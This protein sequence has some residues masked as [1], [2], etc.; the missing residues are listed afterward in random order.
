MYANVYTATLRQRITG[1]LVGVAAIISTVV[2]AVAVYA[3]IEDSLVGFIRDLPE[4]YLSII[5]ISA[6]GGFSSIVLGEM[7][8]LVAPLV[9]AGLAISIGTGAIAGEEQAGTI[10]L[11]LTN[12]I[13]RSEV[14]ISKLGAMITLAVLGGLLTWGGTELTLIAFDAS[15]AEVFVGAASTHLIAIT[16]FFGALAALVGSWTGDVTKSTAVSVTVLIGSFFAAGLLPLVEG[17]ADFARVFPWYYLNGSEPLLNGIDWSHIGVLA[18]A[19][20]VM[21]GG[22]LYGFERRDL[23]V[24][25]RSASVLDRLREHRLVGSVTSRVS[26]TADVKSIW[27]KSFSEHRGVVTLGA[28]AVASTSLVI[29]PLFAELGD[30][31]TQLGEAMPEA[32]LAAVGFA[33]FSTPEGWYWVEVFSIVVPAA[34]ITV[35][36][37]A[38]ARALAGEEQAQTMDLLLANPVKRSRVVVEKAVAMTLLSAVL[39]AAAFAGTL[40]GSVIA[41]LG[42]APSGI[43]AASLQAA[44]LGFS[45]GGMALAVGAATGSAKSAG[46]TGAGVA[47]AAYVAN[48]FFPISERLSGWAELSPFYYYGENEPLVNGVSL[49]NLAVLVALGVSLIGLAILA[50]E[51]RDLR[52]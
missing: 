23:Q 29:G 11:L 50:F 12:P 33:D 13:G 5:G 22:A 46:Y 24:G 28:T 27:V 20:L 49:T 37:M 17:A 30:T 41:G 34:V 40:G 16:V 48:A 26:G 6:G 39:G 47:I 18:A 35:T 7:M 1:V 9:L 38:G 42:M 32:V 43:A 21:M 15:T 52:G 19:S 4:A 36:V 51:R 45:F 3:D 2:M 31:M 25:D 14:L 10:G 44:A 8:N